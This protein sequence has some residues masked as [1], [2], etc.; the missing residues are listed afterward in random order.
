MKI[1]ALVQATP[2]GKVGDVFDNVEIDHPSGTAWV[3]SETGF[4]F[5]L[6]KHEFEVVHDG[7]E[8]ADTERAAEVAPAHDNCRVCGA[9]IPIGGSLCDACLEVDDA[10]A[11]L[12]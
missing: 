12:H 10:A 11:S 6:A 4:G 2:T 3:M 1:R 9:G 8:H 7:P 5:R